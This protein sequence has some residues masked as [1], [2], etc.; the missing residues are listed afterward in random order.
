[1]IKAEDFKLLDRV[2]HLFHLGSYLCLSGAFTIGNITCRIAFVRDPYSVDPDSL[3]L[4]FISRF[5]YKFKDSEKVN[6]SGSN[7]NMINIDLF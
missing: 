3:V 2:Y 4:I 6:I 7:I 1:M 5:N